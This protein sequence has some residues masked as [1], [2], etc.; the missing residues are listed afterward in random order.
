MMTATT[1]HAK[2]AKCRSKRD[3]GETSEPSGANDESS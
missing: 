3:F 1:T 2:R